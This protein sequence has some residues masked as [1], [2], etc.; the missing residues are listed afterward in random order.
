LNESALIEYN[1]ELNS[2]ANV[3]DYL[4]TFT[5]NL[6]ITTSN[7]INLQSSSLAQLTQATNQLTRAALVTF[8]KEIFLEDFLFLKFIL[9]HCIKSMLSIICCFIFNSRTSSI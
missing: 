4:M 6:L 8:R 7:S 3:R 9:E 1:V 5:N 2:Q